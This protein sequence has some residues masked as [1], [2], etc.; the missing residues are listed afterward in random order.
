MAEGRQFKDEDD[1]AIAK[2]TNVMCDL[3]LQDVHKAID[4]AKKNQSAVD[5]QEAS[6]PRQV[7]KSADLALSLTQMTKTEENYRV[8]A[9]AR[10]MTWNRKPETQAARPSSI[11]NSDIAERP[12]LTDVFRGEKTIGSGNAMRL[13]FKRG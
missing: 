1:E 9:S 3:T 5:V 13:A 10:L 7:Q 6:M 8:Q 11:E 4:I 2:G 12:K